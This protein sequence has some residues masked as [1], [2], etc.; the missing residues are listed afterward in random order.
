MPELPEAETIATQLDRC[1]R[2]IQLGRVVLRRRDI[3]RATDLPLREA[4]VG[5]SVVR[6]TRRGKRV[7][8]ELEP[9][10]TLTFGLG[11]TGQLM[12]VRSE[13][14]RDR[15]VH[16]RIGLIAPTTGPHPNPLPGGEGA[17]AELR[18]RDARRFGGIWF[19]NGA[20][21]GESAAVANLGAE[22]L[23]VTA[24][25]FR[26]L[27]NRRRQIKAMLM[28]QH[29]L[30]GLGNI[31]CDEALF[32]ARI[33]PL[34]RGADLSANEVIALHRAIRRTLRQ[35]IRA[36]GSTLRDYRGAD[37]EEGTF[38]V[39]HR[40]YGREGQPCSRCQAAIVRIVAAGRG[41]HLCPACQVLPSG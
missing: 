29:V 11:M 15:H 30:A 14:P 32:E 6:V 19:T 8:L 20:S 36:G 38:Q 9:P 10:A 13:A 28:D 27:V 5:R 4:L 35:A 31:Y 34:R 39:R 7:V 37:G 33:H 21:N 2:G 23:A 41:T 12:V 40:V 16:L 25:E 1:L 18:F 26:A 3:V 17:A 22:P 24:A